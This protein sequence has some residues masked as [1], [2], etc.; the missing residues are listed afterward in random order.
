MLFKRFFNKNAAKNPTSY[1]AGTLKYTL[2]QML[3]VC[4]IL[5]LAKQAMCLVCFTL[6]PT[7]KPLLLDR[8]E[9]N[10]FEIALIVSTI[11]SVLNFI[12]NPVI[13]TISDRT[14]TKY[15][16][17]IPYLIWSAPVLAAV[18]V[19]IGFTGEI[20]AFAGWLFPSVSC[21]WNFWVLAVLIILFQIAFIIPG[22]LIYYLEAEVV[23]QKYLGQYLAVA[24]IFSMICTAG[25]SY[26]LT[27]QCISNT[28]LVFGAF[29]L[30]Y[31]LIYLLLFLFVKEGEFPP[32]KKEVESETPL[33]L[34]AI[35]YCKM[36]FR[37]CFTR[38]I[39]ICL[40]ICTGLN[41]AS[42]ICRA[43]FNML[44]LTKGLEISLKD[45][46]H[47]QAFAMI[48]SACV[49]YFFGKLMD[50]THPMLVYFIG[51]ILVMVANV[52]GY[53]FCVGVKTYFVLAIALTL[54]YAFQNIAMVP[55]FVALFPREKF[56]Q[57]S[58]ANAMVNNITLIIGSAL[59]GILTQYCGY[60][61]MFVWDFILTGAATLL[62]I[63]VYSEW[64]RYGGRNYQAPIVD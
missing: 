48:V 38:K 39:Y 29:A 18:T 60:R 9:A 64:K 10:S 46:G 7:V 37:Q 12:L 61:I 45:I 14:R 24:Q 55:L 53:F 50:R 8:Y 2:G 47:I 33:L 15:G 63:V 56:G 11:P 42:V 41:A 23:P 27:D 43:M 5:L 4:G 16:R 52:Y 36:F 28:K 40:C 32:P 17:R 22:A 58:S 49:I 19:L 34:R 51:G 21:N 1:C 57:Y 25:F 6:V 3:F 20:G 62:L 30:G 35:Q 54:V 59:G 26:F 31:L 44:F 13:S